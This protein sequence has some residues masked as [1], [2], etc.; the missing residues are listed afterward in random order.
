MGTMTPAERAVIEAAKVLR[1]EGEDHLGAL[2]DAVDALVADGVITGASPVEDKRGKVVE[3]AKAMIECDRDGRMC[4]FCWH[5]LADA[6]DALYP[7]VPEPAAP[8]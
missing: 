2:F 1:E 7:P 8:A 3:A 5:D 6:V 4:G